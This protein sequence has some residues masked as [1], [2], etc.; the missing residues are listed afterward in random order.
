M[1]LCQTISKNCADLCA[2]P[3]T[4]ARKNPS[5]YAVL[6]LHK[7]KRSNTLGG[8]RISVTNSVP[9]SGDSRTLRKTA[10]SVRLMVLSVVN[11]YQ[12]T[13]CQKEARMYLHVTLSFIM[14]SRRKAGDPSGLITSSDLSL[15][16]T[17]RLVDREKRKQKK[18]TKKNKEKVPPPLH[19][20]E[21]EEEEDLL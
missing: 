15:Q 9:A 12:L 21:E 16:A 20:E 13:N 18:V 5:S 6:H 19:E 17:R 2:Q 10:L 4:Y 8:L 3:T 1:N 11:I 7:A 14:I